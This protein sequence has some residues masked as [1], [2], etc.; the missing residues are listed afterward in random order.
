MIKRKP[1]P[2]FPGYSFAG[3][4]RCLHLGGAFDAGRCEAGC[5]SDAA[6]QWWNKL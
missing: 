6:A 1:K 5:A 4:R 2:K 3:C